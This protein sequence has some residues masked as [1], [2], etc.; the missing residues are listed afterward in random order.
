MWY[1]KWKK[2]KCFDFDCYWKN[3]KKNK[4]IKSLSQL[5]CT[6]QSVFKQTLISGGQRKWVHKWSQRDNKQ[7]GPPYLRQKSRK[8]PLGCGKRSKKGMNTWNVLQLFL[9]P[10][11]EDAT[12]T[13]KKLLR[14]IEVLPISNQETSTR[15]NEFWLQKYQL[16][17][18]TTQEQED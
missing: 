1:K 8:L 12:T 16:L 18:K 10:R 6:R 3:V 17:N 13:G 14:E 11:L 4:K 2:L 7:L 15:R 9:N 5:L